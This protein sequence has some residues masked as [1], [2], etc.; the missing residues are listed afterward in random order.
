MKILLP[1][2]CIFVAGCTVS[3]YSQEEFSLKS[4]TK[5]FS[6]GAHA[7]YLSYTASSL[8][9]EPN[10]GV[11]YGG[12]IQYGFTHQ[13]AVAINVQHYKMDPKTIEL[14]N[15]PYPYNEI[16]LI[17]KYIFGSTNS[18][19]RPFLSLGENYARQVEEFLGSQQEDIKA[20]Y[21]GLSTCGGAGIYFYL[22][23]ELTVDLSG[24]YHIGS[25][26][27]VQNGV[28]F[29]D[30]YDYSAFKFMGGFSYHF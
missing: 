26:G 30:K 12:Y 14:L 21:S 22:S 7:A 20:V 4:K 1:L 10:T 25:F 13:I 28:S 19:L 29:N 3:L 17:G 27:V 9:F 16:D 2:V 24:L 11:G 5:G 18:Q 15:A 8:L 6:I 23:P